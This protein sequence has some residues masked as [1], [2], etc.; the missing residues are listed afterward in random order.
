MALSALCGGITYAVYDHFQSRLQTTG[1]FPIPTLPV[2]A[3]VKET[4]TDG[5]QVSG[6]RSTGKLPYLAVVQITAQYDDHGEIV[7]AWSGSGSIISPEGL[8]LTNAHVVL[9]DRESP[10]DFLLVAMTENPDEAP[11]PAYYAEVVQAD[12]GLDFAVLRIITD[13]YGEDVDADS[14][15]LPHVTVGDSD[16]LSLGDELTILGYPGIGGDTI[17]LTGGKVSGF[18]GEAAYGNRAFIKTNATM[19]GGNSGGLAVNESGELVG[20]PT[21]LGYGGKEDVIDCRILADT[22]GDG[23][24]D[25]LDGC[26]PTGG[27]I[28]SLRPVNLAWPLIEKAMRGE[29]AALD[30]YT[31]P[32]RDFP[33]EESNQGAL[34]YQ[35][36]FSDP[37]SG[38]SVFTDED[39]DAGYV[40]GQYQIMVKTTDMSGWGVS[41]NVFDD[42]ILDVEVNVLR[43][44]GEGD[45][46]FI[47]R[48][49]DQ[50]NFYALEISEDGYAAIWKRLNGDIFVLVDWLK[51]RVLPGKAPNMSA[52]CIGNELIIF[53]DGVEAASALDD[54]F[55]SGDI[56]LLASTGGRENLLVAFDNLVVSSPLE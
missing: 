30:D 54:D 55:Y 12:V 20:V 44:S 25:E 39:V 42:V 11:V 45:F 35:E 40:N 6:A 1:S 10:V 36:D 52:S 46:G 13:L 49:V 14:L 8:I 9:P 21:Q 31:I 50:N 32:E 26:I 2:T 23:V 16:E 5:F 15:N 53:L 24:V 4:G 17:T 33:D 47:C 43:A 51:M 19:A 37:D 29:V 56:G 18:T 3:S 7:D 41:G 38:W 22:N 28:N 34:L 48:Y 27:F